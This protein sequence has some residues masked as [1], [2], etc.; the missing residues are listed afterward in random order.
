MNGAP[1]LD[2]HSWVWWIL[3]DRRM[4]SAAV[5]RLDEF[6]PDDRPYLAD[7]SLWEVAMLAERGRLR[8]DEP[9][10]EWL[11]LATH[12]RTLRVVPISA[13]IA[14]ETHAASVLRDPADR[15][16]VATSRI[17]GV[18]LFTHDRTI[19]RSGLVQRWSP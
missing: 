1:L 7:I 2:T 10:G 14:T 12:G 16:I 6:P 13:A 19:H 11:A 8:L 3:R 5:E 18:P 4:D 15:I 17:L 9:L